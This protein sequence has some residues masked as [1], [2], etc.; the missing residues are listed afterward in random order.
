MKVSHECS[1]ATRGAKTR[2]HNRIKSLSSSTDGVL[3][4]ARTTAAC[5]QLSS[6]GEK[7]V[8]TMKKKKRN[9]R[10][11]PT[12]LMLNSDFNRLSVPQ[13]RVFE[14]AGERPKMVSD[15]WFIRIFGE[16][17]ARTKIH[18]QPDYQIPRRREPPQIG[19]SKAHRAD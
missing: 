9:L 3:T 18:P 2:T 5:R 15:C 13:G 7:F 11:T 19:F 6:D 8:D 1:A 4:V 14:P 17:V 12:F 16:S 10:Y